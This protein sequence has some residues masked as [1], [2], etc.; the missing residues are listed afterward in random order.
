[1]PVQLE[2]WPR[3]PG[4]DWAT[5]AQYGSLTLTRRDGLIQQFDDLAIK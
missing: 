5:L 3:L 4:A 1:M 2:L